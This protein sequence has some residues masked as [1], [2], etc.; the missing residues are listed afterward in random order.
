MN[1][2]ERNPLEVENERLKR[3]LAEAEVL[4][5]NIRKRCDQLETENQQLKF[6]LVKC[7]GMISAFE[8]CLKKGR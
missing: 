5:K 4:F 6:E 7:Q 3:E 2:V 1:D 8:F